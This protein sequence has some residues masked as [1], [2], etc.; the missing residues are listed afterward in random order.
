VSRLLL[1]AALATSLAWLL[2]GTQATLPEELVGTRRWSGDFLSY[3]LPNAEYL[4]RRLAQ[5]EL[6]LWDVRHGAGAPF[7]ASL[8][9]GA[10]YPPNWLHAVL[11]T[12]PAFVALAALHVALAVFGAGALAAALGADAVGATLAGVAYATS[13][14]VLGEVWTPPPLYTSAWAPVLWLCVERALARPR[15]R[16][17]LALAL[18]L[19][20]PLLAGWPYGVVIAALGAGLYAAL[21]LGQLLVERRRPPLRELATLL[22]GALLGVALAA[23]QLLPTLELLARSCRALGSLDVAQAVFVDAPHAPSH[24]ARAL[25]E[26]GINDGI[27]GWLVLALAP[28][29]FVARG[30]RAPLAALLAVGL[31]GLLA[32]FPNDAPLYGWLRELPVLGDFRFPYRYRLLTTLALAVAAGVGATQLCARAPRARVPAVVAGALLLALQVATSTRAVWRSMIPF[33]RTVPQATLLRETT[34]IYTTAIPGRFLRAG[35][36][37]RLRAAEPDR[38]V[39]DLE[40]L[41]L[42]HVAQLLT[43]F[44]TG[45]PTCTTRTTGPRV[46]PPDPGV[47][48]VPYYGRIGLP[49]TTERF[50]VLDLFSVS[51]VLTPDRGAA[52]PAGYGRILETRGTDLYFVNDHALPRAHWVPRSRPAPRGVQATAA[53]LVASDFD[54][55]TTVLLHD[56]PPPEAAASTGEG[57][58]EVGEDAPER[59]A[60]RTRSDAAGYVVLADAW[61]PGWD[62]EL[63]GAPVPVLRANLAFRAV[64]VPA[65]EHELVLRYRPR[66]LRTGFAL[67][68]LA[69]AA[70][71]AAYAVER[72][73]SRARSRR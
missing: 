17:A 67:A 49:D 55:R 64:A 24:F 41:S 11:P 69:L 4:G 18:S 63:D 44:E 15:A 48:A 26:R 22:A 36:S 1:V 21:R 33:P 37:G 10:L 5:G 19:A 71:A 62:A 45:V 51:D 50:R 14:R 43:Y 7:L 61:F 3:Y 58:V 28:I 73:V 39:N 40:P 12:Q 23:P 32:S 53:A 9:A 46:P 59:I 27:P 16:A 70:G 42:L 54:P 13:L 47:L 38:V 6:P 25:L 31:V 34:G 72:R 2:L 29:A 8:Q 68:A 57:T 35:W 60:L 66:P 52:I 65:G 56:A 30:R 20:L